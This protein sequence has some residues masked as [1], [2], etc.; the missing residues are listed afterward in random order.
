MDRPILTVVVFTYN[1]EAYVLQSLGGVLSQRVNF[2]YSII[3]TEDGSTDRT[4]S[5][6]QSV[7]RE[8]PNRIMPVFNDK[9]IG[10]NET[11]KKVIPLLSTKYACFLGGDDYWI[12]EYKLQKQVDLLEKY[13]NV[14]FIHTGFQF[15]NEPDGVLGRII[16]SWCWNMP[17]NRNERLVSF[18]S[19]NFTLYPCAST[20]CFR[21]K[22]FV[23][24]FN[25]HPQLLDHGVGEGTLLHASMCMYGGEYKFLPDITTVYRRR[26]KSLSHFRLLKDQII[27]QL[28]YLE[29]KILVFR[30]FDVPLKLYKHVVYQDFEKNLVMSCSCGCLEDFK[31]AIRKMGID[32][33]LLNNKAYLLHNNYFLNCYSYYI[34][35][36]N[37]VKHFVNIE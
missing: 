7:I 22:P 31:S 37:K 14:S 10:L 15:L 12:D 6:I 2:N 4:R 29:L 23:T 25:E 19:H 11:L 8:F 28:N 20:S 9:N 34:R 26:D 35:I 21:V 32:R 36:R 24:C 5:V 18:L 17:E 27:F 30:V 1:Q 33:F 16:D 13:P 3:V